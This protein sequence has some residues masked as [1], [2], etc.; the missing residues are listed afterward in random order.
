MII[1]KIIV[2]PIRTNCYVIK[3]GCACAVIDPGEAD[4]RIVSA[5]GTSRLEYIVL[6]HFHFDHT[7]GAAFLKKKFPGAQILI[8]KADKRFIKHYHDGFA[9][10][11]GEPDDKSSEIQKRSFAD[12]SPDRLLDDGEEIILEEAKLQ[13]L[14]TPGHTPGSICLLSEN[15]IFCGDTIFA[16]G[17]GRTD[18]IGGDES[19]LRRS[20]EKLR[21]KN[22]PGA[23][24]RPGHGK[25][26]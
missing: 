26:F 11:L 1:K 9:I 10:H 18:L 17:V 19:E 13:V 15:G 4:E 3:S 25:S 7:R 23:Q 6:T 24:M 20:L 16:D 2:G 5:I 21:K 8:H 14:H 22:K 12:F